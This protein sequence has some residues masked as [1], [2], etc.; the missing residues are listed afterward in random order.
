[1]PP[2][3]VRQVVLLCELD[4]L[5]GF[6]RLVGTVCE[7]QTEAPVNDSG[8][9]S[10]RSVFALHVFIGPPE[11]F[12]IGAYGRLINPPVSRF[13]MKWVSR[14]IDLWVF[15][16]LPPKLAISPAAFYLSHIAVFNMNFDSRKK[17]VMVAIAGKDSVHFQKESRVVLFAKGGIFHPRIGKSPGGVMWKHIQMTLL[18]NSA[19]PRLR[20]RFIDIE[21]EVGAFRV[22][23]MDLVQPRNGLDGS[24]FGKLPHICRK[25]NRLIHNFP[26]IVEHEVAQELL[27]MPS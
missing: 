3:V 11:E 17:A 4:P 14:L 27:T 23:H 6:S 1:M 25:G 10:L 18:V 13:G 24:F 15:Q 26:S 21:R 20:L 19:G 22:V 5:F 16:K 8:F 2:V 9:I 12:R 7:P